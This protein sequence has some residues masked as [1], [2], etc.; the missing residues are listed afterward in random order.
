MEAIAAEL[1]FSR[2]LASFHCQ[3][4]VE[5]DLKGANGVRAKEVREHYKYGVNVDLDTKSK[6]IVQWMNCECKQVYTRLEKIAFGTDF[7]I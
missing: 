4:M 7:M 2:V 6:I 1:L 5:E 3:L